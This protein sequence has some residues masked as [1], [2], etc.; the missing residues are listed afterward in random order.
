M[1]K[2]KRKSR[3]FTFTLGLILI[4]ISFSGCEYEFIEFDDTPITTEVS[5]KN[6]IVPIFNASCGFSGCHAA[7]AIPPELTSERAYQS[8]FSNN[9][10]TANEP[11]NSLLYTSIASGSMKKYST[12]EQTKLIRAWIEQ[13]ALNN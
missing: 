5:F 10:V 13:G 7:G 6:D 4:G 3:F 12:A 2:M 11:A 1:T 9:M 8:L